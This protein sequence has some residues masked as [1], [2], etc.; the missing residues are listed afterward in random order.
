MANK[1]KAAH[2]CLLLHDLTAGEGQ[3]TD[4]CHAL[5]DAGYL[6]SVPNLDRK[7]VV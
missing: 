3:M 6:A 4:L 7:S 2:G 5:E 1:I